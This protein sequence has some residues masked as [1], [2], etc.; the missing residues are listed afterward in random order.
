M[1]VTPE[2]VSSWLLTLAAIAIAL[3]LVKREFLPSAIASGAPRSAPPRYETAWPQMLSASIP[4]GPPGARVTVAEFV[5]L[6]CPGCAH[7]QRTILSEVMRDFAGDV[8]L[9]FLH[10]PGR[11]HR[12]AMPGAIAAECADAQGRFPEFVNLVLASQDSL[13]R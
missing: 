11:R 12:F 1:R 10:L 9:V 5:D 7:Y 4:M 2:K 8:S 13:G 6:E 3:V